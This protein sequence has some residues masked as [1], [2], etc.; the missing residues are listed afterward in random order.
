MKSRLL[1]RVKQKVA[2]RRK[3]PRRIVAVIGFIVTLLLFSLTIVSSQT[4]TPPSQPAA[5]PGGRQSVST[6]VTKNRYGAGM[7]EYWIFEPDAPKPR[8]AP[9][10]VF[11]HG[12]GGMNPMYFGAGLDHL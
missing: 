8:S 7:Q 11:L 10:I 1:N 5:G 4:P 12:W 6:S 2:R 3:M 9:L